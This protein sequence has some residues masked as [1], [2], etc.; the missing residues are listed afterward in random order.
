M[1]LTHALLLVAGLTLLCSSPPAGADDFAIRFTYR[2]N[3]D[4]CRIPACRNLPGEPVVY[5]DLSVPGIYRSCAASAVIYEPAPAVANEMYVPYVVVQ[6]PRTRYY[7]PNYYAGHRVIYRNQPPRVIHQ[8]RIVH[9][10]TIRRI[11][12]Q[13]CTPTVRRTYARR[14]DQLWPA[15]STIGVYHTRHPMTRIHRGVHRQPAP[16]IHPRPSHRIPVRHRR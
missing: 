12:R 3:G 15:R 4:S 5:Y 6:P 10:R 11:H 9:E 7:R 13:R 1:K 14:T 2:D 8:R 16:R